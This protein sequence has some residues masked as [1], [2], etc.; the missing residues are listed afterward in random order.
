MSEKRL[1]DWLAARFT[2]TNN[3]DQNQALA[4][5]RQATV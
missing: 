1:N 2:G 4:A 3:N 5:Q